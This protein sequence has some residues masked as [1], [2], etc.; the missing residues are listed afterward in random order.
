[1]IQINF[2]VCDDDEIVLD[3]VCQR[4]HSIFKRCGV[5]ATGAKYLSSV[6]LY[7]HIKDPERKY[8]YNLICLDID[9]PKLDGVSLGK[10]IREN[11]P[12]T[13]IIFVSNREDRVFDTILNV[14][15]FGFVRKN[16]FSSDLMDTLRAY[17]SSTLPNTQ[18]P[19]PSRHSARTRQSSTRFAMGRPPSPGAGRAGFPA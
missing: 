5:D 19:S 8:N 6:K 2:A 7:E 14:R 13:E 17:I 11:S 3:A 1:M 18:P 9:M 12:E 10:A 16:N 4:V 15:P